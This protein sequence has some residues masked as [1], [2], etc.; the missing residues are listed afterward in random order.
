V[1]LIPLAFLL[2]PCVQSVPLPFGTR[3]LLDPKG[4]AILADSFL[5]PRPS[6]PLSLDP[7]VTRARIG[8]AAA[9]LAVFI[10]AFHI[11]SGQRRRHILLRALGL[12]GVAAV[13][14]GI[15]HRL[16]GE[17]K[18]YGL[19][20]TTKRTMFIGPFVNPNHSA[21]FLNLAAFV[22]LACSFQRPTIFNRVGWLVATCLCVGGSIAT[23]S[24]GG[25]VSL[26]VGALAFLFLGY[27]SKDQE[28]GARVRIRRASLAWGGLVVGLAVLAAA[29]FGANDLLNRFQTDHVNQ[30]LRLRVWRNSLQLI[31][32]HPFGIGRGAF[33][34][35]FPIYRTIKTNFAVRFAFVENEPLQLLI[36]CGWGLFVVCT[37]AI[38]WAGW[39]VAKWGRRDRVEA[40]LVAGLVAVL[41]HNCVDF[42]LE[43]LGVLLP[44]AAVL[45]TTLARG[46][47]AEP[48]TP[49][50]RGWP[51]IA[52]TCSALVFGIASVAH[53]SYDDF[54]ALLKKPKNASD[55]KLLERAQRSHPTD[56]YYA[57][58][59]A[60]LLPLRAPNGPSPRFHA[61]NRAL[62][63]CPS[64]EQVHIDVARNLWSVGLRRQSLQE[65]RTALSLQPLL[66][67]PALGELHAAGARPVDLAA[68]ASF[69]PIRLTRVAEYLSSL[70][71]PDAA[72]MVLGQAESLGVPPGD[73]YLLRARLQTQKGD[74][75]S[76]AITVAKA[77]EANLRD[78]GLDVLEAKL[79]VLTRQGGA[80]DQAM[81]ILDRAAT[82]FPQAVEVQRAR[83]ELVTNYQKWGAATRSLEGFKRALSLAGASAGEAHIAAARLDSRLSRWTTA[84]DEYRIALADS[85][86]DVALWIEFGRAAFHAG[87]N[88]TAREAFVT[89]DHLSPNS[90]EVAKAFQELDAQAQAARAGSLGG[91]ASP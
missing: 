72:L 25:A 27:L 46:R 90:P 51:L 67:W 86:R 58:A 48:T 42:G 32:A 43:I 70:S 50:W 15:G 63:L 28:S 37:A 49:R 89:A 11:A 60:R 75:A 1:V 73:L 23:L 36:D 91:L 14:I 22:C 44:F 3:A 77:R 6:A 82:Q 8:E 39:R 16:F 76:A 7:P 10:A 38:G 52:L 61:L 13:I 83:L 41:V 40:A 21:E 57:L 18:I 26:G 65:W 17:A 9:A 64:C 34:R 74:F 88:A 31:L 62:A 66:L 78:P 12:A 55:A 24:R 53:A 4:S 29:A 69:E 45:G 19:L 79:L 33:D 5:G 30:D 59:Y 87:R 2:V 81:S 54:D 85:P 47:T 56:Y 71:Q 20:T 84:L 68:I 35:V 80:A